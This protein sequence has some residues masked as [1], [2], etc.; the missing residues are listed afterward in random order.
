MQHCLKS[1]IPLERSLIG[2]HLFGYATKGLPGV[3]IVGL[4]K[5]GRNFKEKIIYLTR[6]DGLLIPKKRFVLCVEFEDE[7][8]NL[9]EEDLRWLELPLLILYWTLAEILPIHQLDNCLSVGKVALDGKTQTDGFSSK[10][11]LENS[12]LQDSLIIVR[13]KEEVP[14]E[15]STLVLSEL[16]EGKLEFK[17]IN[18][19]LCS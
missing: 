15:Y 14:S 16:L 17:S 13:K 3:E 2:V 6:L 11:L 10:L 9:R 4:G 7:S 18:Q 12:E 19:M 1:F 8:K 5:T